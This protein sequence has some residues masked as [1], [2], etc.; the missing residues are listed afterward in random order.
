MRLDQE[1]G[2]SLG[3]LL[4]MQLL[5]AFAAIALFERMSPAVEEILLE[6]VSSQEAATEMLSILAS[7]APEQRAE[8]F[9]QALDRAR[10]SITD[11]R[12]RALV[13]AIAVRSQAALTGD[14][15]A[16]VEVVDSLRQLSA[17]N[18]ELMQEANQVALQ[19]GRAGAWAAVVLGVLTFLIGTTVYRRMRTRIER[20]LLD[21]DATLLAA[22]AGDVLRRAAPLGGPRELRRISQN[23]NWMLD[24]WMLQREHGSED[25][26]RAALLHLLDRDPYPVLLVEPAEGILAMNRG[27]LELLDRE[28]RPA[29][30]LE[31]LRAGEAI[32]GWSVQD[33]P[34]TEVRVLSRAG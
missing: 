9:G 34:N 6:N 26:L 5:T 27:A 23:V 24:R 32:E 20:P 18:R 29:D 31:R 33:V 11:P 22:R 3:V 30:L 15:R 21:V 2:F 17:V 7:P 19:R 28:E 14:L 12:E 10:D 4:F 8:A 16:S 13:E 25:R 1:V